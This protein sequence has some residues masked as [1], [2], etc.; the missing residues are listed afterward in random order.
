MPS[1]VLVFAPD[2]KLRLL[3][4]AAEQ[5][6]DLTRAS[7]IGQFARDL[8][9]TSILQA[10]D[11]DMYTHEVVSAPSISGSIRWSIRRTAFR[12]HGVPHTLLV[13]SDVAS[14][15]RE[16][17]RIAWQKLI[18]VLSHEINN[19]LTPIQSI[20]GSLR[21]RLRE[22]GEEHGATPASDFHRG[23]TVIEERAASLNRFLQAYQR[24]TYLPAPHLRQVPLRELM[25]QLIPLETRLPLVVTP[26]PSVDLLADGDQLSQLLINIIRN[27]V[28]AAI[29]RIAA[30]N[31]EPEVVIDWS[32]V[33][34]EVLVR[35]HDNGPGLTNPA[36]IFVPFYT[37]KPNGSGIGLVLARQIAAAHK[38]SLTLTNRVG[39]RGCTAELRL[40]VCA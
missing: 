30:V 15:L 21:S 13:L 38:G 35:V 29:D 1:P 22:S 17:E 14:A 32:I 24:L 28:D 19:S 20:S 8:G 33:G 36:N 4:T 37:T 40:P 11:K 9:L 23:L 7:A 3:N 5:A 18:R 6:F 16:E 39:A 25:D 27:A 31:A 12:L 2:G 34:A 26:G 10:R